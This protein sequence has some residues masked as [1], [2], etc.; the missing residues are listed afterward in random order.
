MLTLN[1][2]HLVRLTHAPQIGAGTIDFRPKAETTRARSTGPCATG[3]AWVSHDREPKRVHEIMAIFAEAGAPRVE[4]LTS[5][6]VPADAVGVMRD[7]A[8]AYKSAEIF[9]GVLRRQRRN[10][11]API[12]CIESLG[13]RYDDLR[14]EW[15]GE[16][17]AVV[18]SWELF[19]A[20]DTDASTPVGSGVVLKT[21]QASTSQHWLLYG[22]RAF[23]QLFLHPRSRP[24]ASLG[25][26]LDQGGKEHNRWGTCP[27]A[28]DHAV[29]YS[30]IPWGFSG[31]VL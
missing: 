7:G 27:H 3:A 29:H 9:K 4:T 14:L 20:D 8:R 18:A 19:E 21:G 2:P 30:D 11:G 25:D 15:P 5:I 31:G 22:K 24:Y 13:E 1:L 12:R 17:G 16:P 26:F 28:V 6:S 23:N 10:S